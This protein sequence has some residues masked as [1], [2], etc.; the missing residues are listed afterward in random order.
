MRKFTFL[1]IAMML[2]FGALMAQD[3]FVDGIGYK[4]GG[5]DGGLMAWGPAEGFK[6]D[7]VIPATVINNGTTYNVTE[8]RAYFSN[9]NI[10]KA[11]V[12]SLT[13]SEGIKYFT[14]GEYGSFDTETNIDGAGDSV[15]SIILPSTITNT[16]FTNYSFRGHPLLKN[17]TIKLATP[18]TVEP[19]VFFNCNNYDT[20][21]IHIPAGTKAAYVAAGWTT[22]NLG[23]GD[24][25]EYGTREILLV[26]DVTTALNNVSAS[27]INIRAISR[28]SIMV[29]GLKGKADVN[30]YELSGKR[31]AGFT[32]ISNNDVL[33]NSTLKAGLLI[34]KVNNGANTTTAKL[35]FN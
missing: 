26:E 12:K 4:S 35:V 6:G 16:L 1:M 28:N 15:V 29:T 32:Q 33:T 25:P 22:D 11:V 3:F 31:V 5:V 10:D 14:V 30:I 8:V 23:G 24:L 17:F 9:K 21:K 27:T 18:P 19:R 13:L 7:L 2:S 20:I 34:V